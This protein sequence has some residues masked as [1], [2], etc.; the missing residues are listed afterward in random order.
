MSEP[1]YWDSTFAIAMALKRQYPD[2]NL[3]D[4]SLQQVY[5]WTIKLPQFEDD[6][7]IANDGIL[8]EIFQVWL[9]ESIHDNKRS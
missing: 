6:P 7:L 9:E 8:A 1:L 4:V 5:Q 2:L 3:E